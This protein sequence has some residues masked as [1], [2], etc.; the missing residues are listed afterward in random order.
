MDR[1]T[2]TYEL[3]SGAVI[4]LYTY[5]TVKDKREI[6]QELGDMDL[7]NPNTKDVLLLQETALSKLFVG[8][9][10]IIDDL[11]AEEGDYLYN[12]AMEK[13]NPDPKDLGGLEIKQ[14]P[15]DSVRTQKPLSIN[16]N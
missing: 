10:T 11:P 16:T 14:E 5:L 4:E 7:N 3:P 1:P 13:F 15:G 8:D 2:Q 9:K 12:I 6:M